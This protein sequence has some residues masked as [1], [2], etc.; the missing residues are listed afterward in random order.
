MDKPNEKLIDAKQKL[1]EKKSAQGVGVGTDAPKKD[2]LP[3]GQRLV[4]GW[5]VLDL[6]IQPQISTAD[7]KLEISGLADKRAFTWQDFLKLPQ[8][9]LTTDFHCV[10]TWSI[11]DAKVEGVLWKDFIAAVKPESTAAAVMFHSYDGYSTN[12]TMVDLAADPQAMLIH[13]YDG[14]PLERIHGGPVRGWVPTLYAWKSAKWVKG[15]EFM[16]KDKRG[17]WELRGYH[18]HADPWRE[19]RY[20]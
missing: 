12:L 9:K 2:R 15:V 10:T 20:S 19:E 16:P 11:Y 7:W 14:K 4:D 5:P 6:G 3:P 8:T 1:A 18:N 17:F 13:S